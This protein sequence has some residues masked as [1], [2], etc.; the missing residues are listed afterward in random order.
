M[1]VPESASSTSPP[2]DPSPSSKKCS[3]NPQTPAPIQAKPLLP[4][5]HQVILDPAQKFL[6]A[7]DLSADLIHV[8]TSPPT[9]HSRNYQ[10]RP[11]S[12]FPKVG[13]RH[14]VFYQPTDGSNNTYLYIVMET[15]NMVHGYSVTYNPDNTLD[16]TM[17]QMLQL[18]VPRNPSAAEIK[19]TV[20]THHPSL[21]PSQLIF[22]LRC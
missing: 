9:T 12:A 2:P 8:F 11:T 5:I 13:P 14:G 1:A 22:K 19:L 4:Y 20:G 3:S 16:F 6:L 15:A 17:I 18:P 21:P 10:L 7:P